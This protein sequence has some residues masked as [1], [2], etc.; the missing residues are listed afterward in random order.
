MWNQGQEENN[1]HDC[2]GL[3]KD[4]VHHLYPVSCSI[5]DIVGQ[6]DLKQCYRVSFYTHTVQMLCKKSIMLT[7]TAFV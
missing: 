2:C 5:T 6:Q 3:I 1:F 7:K 4:F